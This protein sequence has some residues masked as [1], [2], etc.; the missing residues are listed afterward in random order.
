MGQDIGA[1]GARKW[2]FLDGS[3]P[4]MSLLLESSTA[5]LENAG[6]RLRLLPL[7][8]G[9]FRTHSTD[10]PPPPPPPFFFFFLAPG[11]RGGLG[12]G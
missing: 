1:D 11:K 12:H 8:T 10:P 7:Q 4:T 5:S 9:I 6:E 2:L 3:G